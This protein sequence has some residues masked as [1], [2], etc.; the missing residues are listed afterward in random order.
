MKKFLVVE[1]QSTQS[2]WRNRGAEVAP[3]ECLQKVLTPSEGEKINIAVHNGVAHVDVQ[4]DGTLRTLLLFGVPDRATIDDEKE[5]V[6][7]G[8]EVDLCNIG[9]LKYKTCP[10]FVGAFPNK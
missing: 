8:E 2:G 1:F 4:A 3:I 7:M 6:D 5:L 10:L 9:Y